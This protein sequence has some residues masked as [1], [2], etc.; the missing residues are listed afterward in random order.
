MAD[1]NVAATKSGHDSITEYNAT[2]RLGMLPVV[3]QDAHPTII[4]RWGIRTVSAPAIRA[5]ETK[6]RTQQ[7]RW[8]EKGTPIKRWTESLWVESWVWAL[9]YMKNAMHVFTNAWTTVQENKPQ[10]LELKMAYDEALNDP[11]KKLIILTAFRL[12]IQGNIAMTAEDMNTAVDISLRV[13]QKELDEK[14]ANATT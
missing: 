4:H 1:P 8:T 5:A 13:L 6:G 11:E 3:P 9:F 12:A 2:L 14:E 10:I 7:D